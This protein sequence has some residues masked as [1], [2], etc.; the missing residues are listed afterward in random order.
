MTQT[1]VK[2]SWT[3]LLYYK[4]VKIEG[5][6]KFAYDH[7]KLCKS[8]GLKGRILVADEGINGTVGGTQEITNEYMR[9]MRLDS[10]FKDMEFKIS[11]GAANSFKKIFVRYRPELVT[12]G[13]EEK[14]D[15]NKNGGKYL[16]PE[17]LKKMYD[18]SDDFVIIDMRNDYEANIGRFKNAVTLKMKVFKELPEIVKRDLLPFKNKK[19]VTYC[20]GGIRC[21]KASALL[22]KNG[23]KNVYQLHGGV[24]QFGRKFPDNYWEGKLFVFDE[25]MAIPI[26]S[27]GKE[28]IL[29]QCLHCQKPWDDYINCI[30]AEC[31]KLIILCPG[32]RTKWNDGCSI[33]CTK[34][35]RNKTAMA[36]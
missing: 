30:N 28:K 13:T 15:P 16:E 26:N 23:F 22:K 4:Y 1:P 3:I 5:P 32:C 20:T 12:L 7:L 29:A 24:A 10:R 18:A 19:V 17:E 33:D 9:I 34:T 31:N 36:I 6:E 14:I 21:E 27:P 35:P 11:E 2:S 8:L 25:R